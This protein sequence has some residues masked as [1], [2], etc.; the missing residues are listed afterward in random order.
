MKY[1]FNTYLQYISMEK[2]HHQQGDVVS[3]V[4]VSSFNTQDLGS[5]KR[6]FRISCR[7]PKPETKLEHEF[8]DDHGLKIEK[9]IG[10]QSV[11]PKAKPLTSV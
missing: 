8:D 3:G 5:I 7:F 6:I 2:Q 10:G 9:A 11:C 1:A 4:V